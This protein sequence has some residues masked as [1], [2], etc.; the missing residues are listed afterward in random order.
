MGE[1]ASKE[2]T[3]ED[4]LSSI[5]KIIA[6]ESSSTSSDKSV[7]SEAP[8]VN[9]DIL[10]ADPNPYADDISST[11]N[12][13]Y[14]YKPNVAPEAPTVE[15]SP[16]PAAPQPSER[17]APSTSF[18]E[19]AA[20]FK[21]QP[22]ETEQKQEVSSAPPAVESGS[23]VPQTPSYNTRPATVAAKPEPASNELSAGVRVDMAQAHV[24]PQPSTQ[25]NR[26]PE[27]PNLDEE[28]A[29]KGALMSPSAD[30]AVSGSFDRLKRSVLDDMDAK[31]EAIL[32][33]ML[34]EWLD[35]NLPS[36]VERLVR[37]EIERVAR[38]R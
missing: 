36:L 15:V 6:D 13:D 25:S 5:R 1:A 10:A 11:I 19:I 35:E 21:G 7:N 33:P 14:T 18:A 9:A 27:R 34:R 22:V 32:R 38:G 23:V 26:A 28:G 8:Q 3:M 30:D 16:P 4:I 37:E 17:I 2:P 12:N 31:T 20:R 24:A 29:F